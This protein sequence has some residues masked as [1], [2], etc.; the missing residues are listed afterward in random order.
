MYVGDEPYAHGECIYE[1][2]RYIDDGH[3]YRS[4]LAC[5]ICTAFYASIG[6]RSTATLGVACP[7]KAIFL[8]FFRVSV[9]Q[10]KEHMLTGCG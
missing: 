1:L 3:D 6:E 4:K 7:S 10:P 2:T 8:A 5:T 9:S